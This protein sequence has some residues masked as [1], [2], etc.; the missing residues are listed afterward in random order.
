MGDDIEDL[1]YVDLKHKN[2]SPKEIK[3]KLICDSEK[4]HK[5]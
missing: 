2:N 1:V 3:K 5:L 4:F